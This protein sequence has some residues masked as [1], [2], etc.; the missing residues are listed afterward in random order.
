MTVRDATGTT[1]KTT[2]QIFDMAFSIANDDKVGVQF[3]LNPAGIQLDKTVSL[4]AQQANQRDESGSVY[5]VDF[6][7]VSLQRYYD[8]TSD[9]KY[10]MPI[11]AGKVEG[12]WPTFAF[13]VIGFETPIG[14]LPNTKNDYVGQWSGFRQSIGDTSAFGTFEA[15]VTLNVDFLNETVGGQVAN[16]LYFDTATKSW[17]TS[18]GMNLILL[19]VPVSQNGFDT[20]FACGTSP[21]TLTDGRIFATFYG[22]AAQ[23]AAG[24]AYAILDTT[25]DGTGNI[26]LTGHISTVQ[27]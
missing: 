21:C 17:V 12:G 25:N 19:P 1:L 2:P 7:N 5:M 13:G 22:S 16:Y 20:S 18:P 11:R 27:K 24:G 9:T 8:G 6:A 14:N 23:E 3:N 15:E 4:L 10:H 26:L